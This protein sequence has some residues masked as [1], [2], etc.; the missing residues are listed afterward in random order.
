[1]EGLDAQSIESVIVELEERV[2]DGFVGEFDQIRPGLPSPLA[3][4]TTRVLAIERLLH[5]LVKI[6]LLVALVTFSR[7]H[8][9]KLKVLLFCGFHVSERGKSEGQS[10]YRRS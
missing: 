10:D 8:N 2:G 4:L 5:K 9:P 1:M 6:Q 7:R 3:I